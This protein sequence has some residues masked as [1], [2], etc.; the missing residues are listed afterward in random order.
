MS[1]QNPNKLA[2]LYPP[3]QSAASHTAG[4]Y[5]SVLHVKI[6]H[7]S[8]GKIVI[9]K[10]FR[11]RILDRL[12]QETKLNL[13]SIKYP[14]KE[15]ITTWF[16]KEYFPADQIISAVVDS[17]VR[18]EHY[19]GL[20]VLEVPLNALV[21]TEFNG[22]AADQLTLFASRVHMETL[23]LNHLWEADQKS[24]ATPIRMNNYTSVNSLCILIE[25]WAR[26]VERVPGMC[27]IREILDDDH[28]RGYHRNTVEM[29]LKKLETKKVVQLWYGDHWD[30][31]CV[32]FLEEQKKPPSQ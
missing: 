12:V 28:F 8:P 22:I 10:S 32:K 9:Y 13:H 11:R 25:H 30:E 6:A 1:E 17:S 7:L 18:P 5:P 4:N 26:K 27:G 14:S 21:E 23:K 29:A 15:S 16:R 31:L 20:T 19:V 3:P 24:L 2:Q